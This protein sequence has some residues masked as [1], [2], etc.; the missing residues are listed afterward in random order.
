MRNV[1]RHIE[2]LSEVVQRPGPGL[3]TNQR[4]NGVQLVDLRGLEPL[5]SWLQFKRSVISGLDTNLLQSG[6]LSRGA[7]IRTAD[8][9][10]PR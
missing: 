8:L 2:L 4:D 6:K 3:P 9:L 10:R 7:R 1:C 5:T